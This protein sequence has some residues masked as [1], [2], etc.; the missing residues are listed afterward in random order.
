[1]SDLEFHLGHEFSHVWRDLETGGRQCIALHCEKCGL[2][3]IE[4]RWYRDHSTG[5]DICGNLDYV[6]KLTCDE[7]VVFGIMET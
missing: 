5:R 7:Q 2:R 1:M 6:V 3:V 4:P